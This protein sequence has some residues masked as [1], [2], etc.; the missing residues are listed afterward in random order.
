MVTIAIVAPS[1]EYMI[2]PSAAHSVRWPPP[3]VGVSELKGPLRNSTPCLERTETKKKKEAHR[4]KHVHEH[5][6]AFLRLYRVSSSVLCSCRVVCCLTC[7]VDWRQVLIVDLLLSLLSCCRRRLR[8]HCSH[9]D[10]QISSLTQ[11]A[12]RLFCDDP[13]PSSLSAN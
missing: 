11:S 10:E 7:N 3:V 8:C 2:C 13:P 12:D 1:A 9:V 4:M 5:R 6:A